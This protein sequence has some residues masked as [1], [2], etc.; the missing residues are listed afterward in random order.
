M[1]RYGDI[2]LF[3]EREVLV[4][5]R[6]ARRDSL[7]LESDLAHYLEAAGCEIFSQFFEINPLAGR[8]PVLKGCAWDDPGGRGVLPFLYALWIAKG[9]RG[10]VEGLHLG[11]NVFHILARPRRIKRGRAWLLFPTERLLLIFRIGRRKPRRIW[12]HRCDTGKR[13]VHGVDV[14]IDD[15][16]S[17]AP[18]VLCKRDR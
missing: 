14:N 1:N 18:R 16:R 8:H 17:L 12:T 2:E 3:G 11:E 4:D 13:A 7:I 9:N 10:H 5:R 6:I 15:R